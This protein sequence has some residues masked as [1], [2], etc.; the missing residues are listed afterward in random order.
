MLGGK[1]LLRGERISITRQS[2]REKMPI[3][4]KIAIS[5]A[6]KGPVRRIAAEHAANCYV[7]WEFGETRRRSQKFPD[8]LR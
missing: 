4:S 3:D 8:R 2:E 7:I 1:G 6:L 5:P